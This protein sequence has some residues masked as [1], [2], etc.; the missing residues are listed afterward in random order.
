MNHDRQLLSSRGISDTK[1]L[2][3]LSSTFSF[4]TA[5]ETRHNAATIRRLSIL[6]FQQTHELLGR[7]VFQAWKSTRQV[8]SSL[9]T[10]AMAN[11]TTTTDTGMQHTV[12]QW[13]WLLIE[14]IRLRMYDMSSR[15]LFL[16]IQRITAFL[17]RLSS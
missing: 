10:T 7:N 4:P 15:W 11:Q 6:Q 13:A 16:H 5:H 17:D 9:T 1:G 8:Y 12:C 3:P 2:P 14:S